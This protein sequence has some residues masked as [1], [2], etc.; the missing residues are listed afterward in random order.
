MK[1]QI[2]PNVNSHA[3]VVG[4]NSCEITTVNACKTPTRESNNYCIQGSQDVKFRA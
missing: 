2:L 1:H 3:I 4:Q